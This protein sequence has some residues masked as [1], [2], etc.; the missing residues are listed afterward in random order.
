MINRKWFQAKP[1]EFKV[2]SENCHAFS[3]H[4]S[5]QLLLVELLVELQQRLAAK[6]GVDVALEYALLGLVDKG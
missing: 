5:Q 4:S 3:F 2:I 6:P 1:S